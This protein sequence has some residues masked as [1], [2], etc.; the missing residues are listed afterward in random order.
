VEHSIFKSPQGLL[1]LDPF[2]GLQFWQVVREQFFW[3]HC[4]TWNTPFLAAASRAALIDMSPGQPVCGKRAADHFVVPRGT[5]S[6]AIQ[7]GNPIRFSSIR[8]FWVGTTRIV[9]TAR[10]VW[11]VCKNAA[12]R[13]YPVKMDGV[14]SKAICLKEHTV[15]AARE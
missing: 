5:F 3:I 7:T 6:F 11:E 1:P 15:L 10:P 14:G 2:D 12:I 4:S 13:P 8:T 9:S